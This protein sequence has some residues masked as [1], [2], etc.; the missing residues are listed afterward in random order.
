MSKS[1]FAVFP[2]RSNFV[3]YKQKTGMAM[4][5]LSLLKGKKESLELKLKAIHKETLFLLETFEESIKDARLTLSRAKFIGWDS[6]SITMQCSKQSSFFILLRPN[7]VAGVP[8]PGYEI[9]E[10]KL[11]IYPLTGLACGGQHVHIVRAAYLKALEMII[12]LGF[13]KSAEDALK[14]AAYKCNIRINGIEYVMLPKLTQTVYYISSELDENDR[15]ETYR[16]KKSMQ[17]VA[18][19]IKE[20]DRERMKLTMRKFLDEDQSNESFKS[21]ESFPSFNSDSLLLFS[22]ALDF[23]DS[24][25]KR[26]SSLLRIHEAANE[27]N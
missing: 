21:L 4:R 20:K 14:D 2:S 12:R 9:M 15:E 6:R 8:V 22:S 13:L 1:R 23:R 18:R 24:I 26:Y 10:S 5:G 19:H 7:S 17:A 16:L 27:G 25:K 3:F 11:Q